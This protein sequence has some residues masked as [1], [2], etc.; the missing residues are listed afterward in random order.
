MRLVPLA[1]AG[2]LAVCGASARADDYK[3]LTDAAY[4][5]SVYAN[6]INSTKKTFGAAA[7]TRDAQQRLAKTSA[8]V[9]CAVKL[10]KIDSE[11]TTKLVAVG[12]NDAHLCWEDTVKC[13]NEAAERAQKDVDPNLQERMQKNCEQPTEPI[14]KRIAECY[15]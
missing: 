14:C 2:L 6:D 1:C 5:A 7:D 10:A 12:Q 4:C 13:A 9:E 3:E 15:K 8:F 11:T